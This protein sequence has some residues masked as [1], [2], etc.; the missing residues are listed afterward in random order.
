M[1]CML[2]I[3]NDKGAKAVSCLAGCLYFELPSMTVTSIPPPSS[4]SVLQVLV[5]AAPVAMANTLKTRATFVCVLVPFTSE[6]GGPRRAVPKQRG[7]RTP[8]T[9]RI[10]SFANSLVACRIIAVTDGYILSAVQRR[11]VSKGRYMG[12]LLAQPYHRPPAL[13]SASWYKDEDR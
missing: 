11:S 9:P 8:C 6:P 7:P 4:C 5:L 1:L 13:Q 2:C 12:R 10:F 3:C